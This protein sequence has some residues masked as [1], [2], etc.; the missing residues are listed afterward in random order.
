LIAKQV[1]PQFLPE[2]RPF[3]F[4]EPSIAIMRTVAAPFHAGAAMEMYLF[5]GKVQSTSGKRYWRWCKRL[6]AVAFGC[7]LLAHAVAVVVYHPILV[8]ERNI[9]KLKIGDTRETMVR[10]V[11]EPRGSISV[12]QFGTICEYSVYPWLMAKNYRYR[13]RWRVV[14]DDSDRVVSKSKLNPTGC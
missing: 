10:L 14:L 13:S 12:P 1:R 7:I 4:P 6:G 11:G 5:G 9:A 2:L 3:L 8:H